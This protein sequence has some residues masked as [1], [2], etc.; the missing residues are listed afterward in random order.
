MKHL[1]E[2]IGYPDWVTDKDK[3]NTYYKNITLDRATYFQNV[4][5]MSTIRKQNVLLSV[6]KTYEESES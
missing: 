2:K 6:E 4:V 1:H 3:V 5:T